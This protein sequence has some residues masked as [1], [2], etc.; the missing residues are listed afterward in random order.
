[1]ENSET[2]VIIGNGIASWRLNEELEKKFID[3]RIVRIGRD[4]FAP[5]CSLRT[6]SINCLRGTEKGISPLGDLIVDSQAEFEAFYISERPSGVEKGYEYQLWD[7]SDDESDA[8]WSKRHK[9][10][11]SF[12]HIEGIELKTPL[13]GARMP[14]YLINPALFYLWQK[15]RLKRSEYIQDYVVEA[16]RDGKGFFVRT[17]AGVEIYADKLFICAGYLSHHFMDL[18]ED[19][20]V[21]DYLSRC[22]PVRGSFLRHPTGEEFNTSFSIAFDKHHLIFRNSDQ[23]VLLGSTSENDSSLQTPMTEA[24][25]EIYD[26][27]RERLADPS[28]LPPKED[29]EV[30]SGIRHKGAKRMPFWGELAPNCYGVFGLYKNAFSFSFLAAKELVR[31]VE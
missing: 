4:E 11:D 6:T 23:S 3:A 20:K 24:L 27:I 18:V 26:K 15:S 2:L 22:K 17:Q 30:V 25:Y 5:K 7:G 28:I 12:G 16:R 31:D 8:R 1:M 10:N 21:L 14:A 19:E 13:K 9:E 29:W